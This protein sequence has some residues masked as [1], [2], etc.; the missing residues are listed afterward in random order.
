MSNTEGVSQKAPEP[1]PCGVG[2]SCLEDEGTP[3]SKPQSNKASFPKSHDA[4]R[5]ARGLVYE[6]F[7]KTSST[8][9]EG[10]SG[11]GWSRVL[12]IVCAFVML[13]QYWK[14]RSQTWRMEVQEQDVEVKAMLLKE[15]QKQ[16]R[17]VRQYLKLEKH[18]HE[19]EL[20]QLRSAQEGLKLEKHLHGKEL[21]KLRSAQ[22]YLSKD[23][24]TERHNRETDHKL[25][26]HSKKAMDKA[27][28]Q[29]KE[30]ERKLA[31]SAENARQTQ[32]R[33]RA[34]EARSIE[35]QEEADQMALETLRQRELSKKTKA[36]KEQ[37]SKENSQK[38]TLIDSIQKRIVDGR[39]AEHK[40]RQEISVERSKVQASESLLHESNITLMTFQAELGQEHAREKQLLSK[41]VND[42]SEIKHLRKK[43]AS[44]SHKL[45]EQHDV[46]GK[47]RERARQ[48][49][50]RALAIEALRENDQQTI[51]KVNAQLQNQVSDSDLA[52]KKHAEDRALQRG[53]DADLIR[54]LQETVRA[55]G[56]EVRELRVQVQQQKLSE[57]PVD[58]G[59]ESP[60]TQTAQDDDL[61]ED[62]LEPISHHSG[63]NT[64][65]SS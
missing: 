52:E 23:L 38:Q 7:H 24:S 14:L 2:Q 21:S 41:L 11:H 50:A 15:E 37:L 26:S 47:Y 36:Q 1:A 44:Q 9:L 39:L 62:S 65:D 10:L 33:F 64:Q 25:T 29:M 54:H 31:Q 8:I 35:L 48:E 49:Q 60:A 4:G 17:Q 13:C 28:H 18:Q 55:Q 34:A 61:L 32:V 12:L 57:K 20:S 46:A 30:M 27:I 19:K 43:I 40:L 63:D 59:E 56:S 51:E 58:L 5:D 6:S 42:T 22:E 16:L 53:R 3:A 45:E